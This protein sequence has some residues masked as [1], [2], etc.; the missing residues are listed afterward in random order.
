ME[1]L[2]QIHQGR[3]ICKSMRSIEGEG[4]AGGERDGRDKESRCL[5]GLGGEG[6]IIMR[7]TNYQGKTFFFS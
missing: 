3:N 7:D 4:A 6:G 1:R 5:T 2:V